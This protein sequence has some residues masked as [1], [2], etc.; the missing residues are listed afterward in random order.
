[1]MDTM[2]INQQT[3]AKF[4]HEMERIIENTANTAAKLLYLQIL[5]SNVLI[6]LCS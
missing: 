4:T 3:R 1:M 6:L 2:I 5:I